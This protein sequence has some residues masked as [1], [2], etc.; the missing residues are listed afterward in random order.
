M[1]L[2]DALMPAARPAPRVSPAAA[3]EVDVAVAATP[4][5]APT[6]EPAAE[7]KGKRWSGERRAI[8]RRHYPTG[9]DAAEIADE[10]NALPGPPVTARLVG[11]YAAGMGLH[12]P[13]RTRASSPP[14]GLEAAEPAR[15]HLVQEPPAPVHGPARPEPGY[16]PAPPR[17]EA[18]PADWET[19]EEWAAAQQ[20]TAEPSRA[21]IRRIND[22]RLSLHLSPFEVTRGL[23]PM[24]QRRGRMS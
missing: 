14:P 24:P 20:I 16:R 21:G 4:V 7:P 19:V 3:S 9:L 8:L 1:R 13:G 5:A 23:P 17:L 6:S 18:V 2:V 12:R 15:L 10:C 22:R 11:I